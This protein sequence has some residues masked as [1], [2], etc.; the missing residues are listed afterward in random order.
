MN[1]KKV[2][3]KNLTKYKQMSPVAKASIALVFVKFL[4]KGISMISG[5]IFTR[6]MPMDE[7]GIVSTFASWQS[8]LY[9][10]FTLNMSAGVFNNGMVDFKD[11]RDG[12]SYSIM[13]LAHFVTFCW[14]AIYFLFYQWLQ[15]IV[16]MSL[17]LMIILFLYCFVTPAYN[18]WIGRERFVFR[19][20]AP[21]TVMSLVTVFSTLLGII[22]VL[23][24]ADD[25][26]AEGKIIATEIPA[27]AVGAFFTVKLFLNNRHKKI[28]KYWK[29]AF[30]FNAPLLVHYLSMYVLSSSDRIMITK[31]VGAGDTAIYNVAYT[32]ASIILIFEQSIDA[33]Y[34]P[35]VYQKMEKEEYKSIDK[36]GQ[37]ILMLFGGATLL[38]ALFA[39]EIMSVLAPKSYYSGVY[40]VPAVAASVFFTTLYS[41]F[42][43]VELYCKK[44]TIITIATV[45]SALINIVLNYI[46]IPKFGFVAAGYT[47]LISYVFLSVFHGFNLYRIGLGK[48]YNMRN[49]IFLS[50]AVLLVTL[51]INLVYDYTLIRYFFISVLVVV[52]VIKRKNIMSLLKKPQK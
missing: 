24:L 36:R 3:Q 13:G 34:A 14:T 42:M 26:K 5:P 47:T 31:L 43:R 32:V 7:Y 46:L 49:I 48:I 4:Q 12:F 50:L 15:P 9:I 38:C 23:M 2:L 19:Y 16:D 17:V 8:V 18:Y 52:A 40:V 22:I 29:Y 21:C 44:T 28:T 6:I 51:L 41:L 33:S 45:M 35:W 11:D 20:K 39:P 10:V 30:C 27:I 37:Q 1:I 25:L